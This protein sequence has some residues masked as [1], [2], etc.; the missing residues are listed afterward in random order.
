VCVCVC[1]R[2]CVRVCECM[3]ARTCVC[4]SVMHRRCAIRRC[5]YV[6]FE[7]AKNASRASATRVAAGIDSTDTE[8]S[9]RLRAMV[10]ELSKPLPPTLS[11]NLYSPR[12]VEDGRTA[13]CGKAM[14]SRVRN[15]ALKGI[16]R[17]AS[18]F[19]SVDHSTHSRTEAVS[20]VHVTPSASSAANA[21]QTIRSTG[22]GNRGT[23]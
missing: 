1:V 19:S 8:P 12:Y 23:V 14:R 9:L 5:T 16:H 11:C 2:V 3:C 15:S 13:Y 17:V 4:V 6:T 20:R 10:A 21:I 22:F 18:R 7:I